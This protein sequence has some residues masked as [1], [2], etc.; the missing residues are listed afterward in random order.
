MGMHTYNP[1]YSGGGDRRIMVQEQPWQKKV[2]ILHLK[3]EQT[4]KGWGRA[5]VVKH[6][7]SM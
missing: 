7:L 3:N 1:N 2:V 6:L 5:Q 4:K